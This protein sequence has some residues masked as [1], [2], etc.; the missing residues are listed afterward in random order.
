M[1]NK[2][3]WYNCFMRNGGNTISKN[4]CPEA[5]SSSPTTG[6]TLVWLITHSEEILITGK[7]HKEARDH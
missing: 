6:L 1:T 4:A 3:Q 2:S 7:S 5:E